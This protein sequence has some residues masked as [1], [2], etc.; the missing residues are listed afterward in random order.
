MSLSRL[1]V[2]LALLFIAAAFVTVQALWVLKKDRTVKK[3]KKM[4]REELAVLLKV[5]LPRYSYEKIGKFLGKSRTWV[6]NAMKKAREG[7]L[8]DG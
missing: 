8:I 6:Y 4:S 5:S 7:G 2:G 1:Y 3:Y